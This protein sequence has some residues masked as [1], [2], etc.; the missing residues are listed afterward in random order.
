M[1]SKVYIARDAAASARFGAGSM[2][3]P[4]RRVAMRR[5]GRATVHADP[6]RW[7][8]AGPL[9]A[10]RLACQYDAFVRSVADAGAHIDWIPDADDGLADSIFV[11][12]PSFMTPAGAVLLRPGKVLRR[13][14]VAL[15]GALYQRLGI[16]VLGAIEPPGMMEGGDLMWIDERTLAAARTFRT[17]RAGIEQLRTILDPQG[18]DV[19]AFDLPMWHG[20]DACLHLL[21][22]ISPLDRDL[23]LI[24]PRLL[25]VALHRFIGERGIRCIEAGDEEFEASGGLCLNVLA[26]GPR[27]CIAVAGFPDTLRLMRD[28]GCEV[29]CF[30]ADA[31]CMPCEGG[32]T[33][34]TLPLWR[35]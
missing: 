2:V 8:Y 25:P 33:C 34:L 1:S 17:N 14:E 27:R 32:P 10:D 13:P 7:H 18:V 5:P 22:V 3:V 12:D 31:L 9:D 29:T 26:M 23:A 11:F 20:S 15:H 4:L 16:P 28:A 30:D 35:G 19:H 21:S 24:Y 6:A